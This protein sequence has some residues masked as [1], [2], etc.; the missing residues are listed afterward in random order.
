MLKLLNVSCTLGG[1]RVLQNINFSLAPGTFLGVIGPNGAGKTTLLRLIGG[2]IGPDEGKI[3][4]EGRDVRFFS[5]QELSRKVAIVPQNTYINFPFTCFE[6]VL[7]GRYPH[8]GHFEKERKKD[9]E[10]VEECMHLTK[11]WYLKDRKV[12]QISGGELQRVVIAQALAQDTPLLLLDEPT[13][14]LDINNQLEILQI[15]YQ[16]NRK[17]G[18]S[19]I[20]VSHD[21]N[22]AARW[23]DKLI[24]LK[25]GKI[26]AQ[27]EVEKVLTSENIRSVYHINALVK[28]HP[29]TGFVYALPISLL[30]EKK[31]KEKKGRVHLIG[32]GGS[33]SRMI[34][35]L[36]DE[37]YDISLGVVNIFDADFETAKAF[38][39]PCVV[40]APFSPITEDSYKKNI[41]LID[42]CQVVVLCNVP[43]GKGNL[44][45]LKSALQALENKAK[46]VV[47]C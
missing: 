25:E 3:L 34:R 13:S 4:V 44:L 41:Q 20:L 22:I 27:G 32:G 35:E 15:I 11:T 1:K 2:L 17:K 8:L 16:L 31:E 33:A 5:R 12:T 39:I 30:K 6:V 45:N 10:K 9:L 18:K 36:V 37:G 14:H 40:E 28:K 46:V 21:L 42:E 24:L 43:F 29:L 38:G 19:I 7:M 47:L 26:F 23:C